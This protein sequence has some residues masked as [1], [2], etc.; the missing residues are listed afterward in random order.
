NG[1]PIYSADRNDRENYFYFGADNTFSPTLTG[2][3]RLGGRYVNYYND[4]SGGN[5][6]W[7]PYFLLNVQY[8]YNPQSYLEAGIST[9]LN[10]TDS[11]SV[12]GDSITQTEESTVVH[13][14]IN[15]AI[16]PKLIG[17]VVALFQYSV[18]Q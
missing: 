11:F 8:T 16:S 9:D 15:H 3:F 10:A 18:F 2:S 17:S 7:G 14:S 1:T 13:G 6:G 4:A 12:Q 5:N